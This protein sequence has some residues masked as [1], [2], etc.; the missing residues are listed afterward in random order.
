MLD[1]NEETRE[2]EVINMDLDLA[3]TPFDVKRKEKKEP[4]NVMV[5]TIEKDTINRFSLYTGFTVT[6]LIKMF[7]HTLIV[8]LK[9]INREH[10]KLPENVLYGV[11]T[12]VL[13]NA[14]QLLLK[15]LE[16]KI[17]QAKEEYKGRY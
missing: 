7:L 12:E 5:T 17:A 15:E 6:T 11:L 9:P 8:L 16:D 13:L 2:N 1:W 3:G 14:P 4:I 10:T